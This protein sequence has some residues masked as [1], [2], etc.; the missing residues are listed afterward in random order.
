MTDNLC[1]F[2]RS[3]SQMSI[4]YSDLVSSLVDRDLPLEILNRP[5]V[6]LGNVE[7]SMPLG[8]Q[9]Q[10]NQV[11]RVQRKVDPSQRHDSLVESTTLGDLPGEPS[12]TVLGAIVSLDGEGDG[13]S[14]VVES[15]E[16]VDGERDDG[17]VLDASHSGRE[18]EEDVQGF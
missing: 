12:L 7:T 10:K 3:R 6:T 13:D 8:Q 14:E 2:V 4:R 18:L 9:S 17:S 11:D 15:D 1:S 5:Q 16:G